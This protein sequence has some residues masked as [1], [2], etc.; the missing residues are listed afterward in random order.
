M[1]KIRFLI[2]MTLSVAMFAV[3]CSSDDGT[4]T[5]TPT[6]TK[7]TISGF[8]PSSGPVGTQVTIN[9]T[10]FST[11]P[12]SNTVK[13]GATTATVST[14]TATKLTISVPQGATTGAVSVG[15]GG[16]TVT[17]NTFTVTEAEAQNTAPV[18]TNQTTTTEVDENANNEFTIFTVTAT[19]EDE[20]DTLTFEITDGNDEEL[21]SIDE[22][23]L[24]TLADGKNLDYETTSGHNITVTVSD[25][26]GGTD[27]ISVQ[28]AVKNVIENLF[29]DPASFIFTLETAGANEEFNIEVFG[30]GEDVDFQ[31]D[32]GDG[33][34]EEH[35][36]EEEAYHQYQTADTYTVALKGQVGRLSFFGQDALR[37]VEQW[38]DTAWKSMED[39]F[40]LDNDDI[41]VAINA[42]G[43][44]NLEQCTSFSYAFPNA[45]FKQD[46]T[47]WDVDN[48]QT[49][50]NTFRGNSLFNQDISGWDVSNVED[51]RSMFFE[52][53]AFD[54]DISGWDVSQ[55]TNMDYMFADATAF[56]QDLGEWEIGNV[57]S[58]INMFNDSGMSAPNFSDTLIG[59]AD[60]VVQPNVVLGATGVDLCIGDGGIAYN[61][62]INDMGPNWD[63]DYKDSVFCP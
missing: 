47:E 40:H 56:D 58:M 34:P 30:E 39:M 27:Q 19:D 18:I 15:V 49:M 54:Q 3:S 20:G 25:G 8:T 62:L 63:I 59:W 12:A 52:A 55:V 61:T 28:I 44:P 29:E 23:G 24:I 7:P 17:G 9:G 11:T 46:I 26:N 36:T 51:M 60:Q 31:I 5:P 43:E 1:K 35:V 6:P 57:S 16:E 2:L 42:T 53:T 33:Q 50:N 14:A 10:N 45:D 22:S 37:T 38:G 4:T 41:Y 13:I 21:F 32:W 48:V